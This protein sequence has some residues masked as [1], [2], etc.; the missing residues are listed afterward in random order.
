[1]KI[2]KPHINV[3]KIVRCLLKIDIDDMITYKSISELIKADITLNKNRY[4][5]LKA[6]QI[7]LEENQI[8]FGVIRTIGLKRLNDSE[9]VDI[10]ETNIQKTKVIT[11]KSIETLTCIADY[12][13]LSDY[14]KV[15]YNSNMTV[16]SVLNFFTNDNSIAKIETNVETKM[17]PLEIKETIEFFK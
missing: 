10:G 7:V 16:L 9:I 17:N 13:E 1:M 5:L 11:S 3:H 2:L 6:R 14:K 12:D 4:Y 15:K 8:V